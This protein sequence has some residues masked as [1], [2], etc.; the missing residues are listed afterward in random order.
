MTFEE[1][2]T[3]AILTTLAV[4]NEDTLPQLVRLLA[5]CRGEHH[6]NTEE[7]ERIAL[8]KSKWA[9]ELPG[10]VAHM[11]EIM[12]ETQI[13]PQSREGAAVEAGGPGATGC[14]PQAGGGPAAS[15]TT[16]EA[17]TTAAI[18]RETTNGERGAESRWDTGIGDDPCEVK[19]ASGSDAKAS[20]GDSIALPEKGREHRTARTIEDVR[21]FMVD[22]GPLETGAL[23]SGE[24]I[25]PQSE[26][27]LTRELVAM[28]AESQRVV[29]GFRS[30]LSA[31]LERVKELDFL[32]LC[33]ETSCKA[34]RDKLDAALERVKELEGELTALRAP[35]TPEQVEAGVKAMHSA[36]GYDRKGDENLVRAI[37]DAV[38]GVKSEPAK[39]AQPTGHW[40]VGG[41]TGRTLYRENVFMGLIDTPELAASIVERMNG[42]AEAWNEKQREAVGIAAC[43]HS[44]MVRDIERAWL[45]AGKQGE[46]R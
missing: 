18:E 8:A 20:S 33:S 23:A 31:A 5:E 19:R 16:S 42:V 36:Y 2:L 43:C 28:Q 46:G 27:R 9:A 3:A 41:T 39:V 10:R 12:G 32:R 13:P 22:V 44:R 14:L 38:Q 25:P 24:P 17:A 29:E 15:A 37:V 21:R 4:Q 45:A 30:N 34:L 40:R 7:T 1:K 11:K 26:A 6:A 35:L